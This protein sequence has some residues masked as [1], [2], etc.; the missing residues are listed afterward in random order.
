MNVEA[1][2]FVPAHVAVTA[3]LACLYLTAIA[4]VSFSSHAAAQLEVIPDS[5]P[6]YS[7]QWGHAAID[8]R[9]A[10]NQGARGAG[11]RVAVIDSGLLTT[12][13]DVIG[14]YE[15]EVSISLAE[16]KSWD[17]PTD[18]HGT[19]VASVIAGAD[20]GTGVV[21]VAP[22][23]KVVAIIATD[24]PAE[25]AQGLAD[26]IV[27]A[28]DHGIEVINISQ[29]ALFPEAGGCGLGDVVWCP[30]ADQLADALAAVDRAGRYAWENGTLVLAASGNIRPGG[31][32][33]DVETS[34]IAIP[35]DAEFIFTVSSTGPIGWAK[36]DEIFLDNPA[37]YSVT[38]DG[39][40]TF[41]A[42]G[43]GAFVPP[44]DR[45][46][47]CTLWRLSRPCGVFDNILV[48][49]FSPGIVPVY[50][51]TNG[52]SFAAPHASGVAA[53]LF[54]VLEGE[55]RTASTVLELMRAGADDLGSPG[56]DSD[57]GFGRL[58]AGRSVALALQR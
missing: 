45:S 53:L 25:R 58:N 28:V 1:K 27:Y 18:A 42:P 43:G 20:N 21:G 35:G 16:G 34:L 46:D 15:A 36:D 2:G 3:R 24:R 7:L 17:K 12:H 9:T 47:V 51:F 4:S 10:W 33:R 52:T 38:G 13:P 54:S 55:E 41:G 31:L 22:E 14:Q 49:A 37:P 23:A 50:Q 32:N 30:T 6:A 57:Y 19:S 56:R 48:A 8:V 40:V 26:A 39:Y 29:A 44:I 11:V 5:V